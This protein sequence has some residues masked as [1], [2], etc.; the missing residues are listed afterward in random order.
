MPSRFP[1]AVLAL[2]C[3][4]LAL[5]ASADQDA[6]LAELPLETLLDLPV[7][8]ASR[9]GSRR[10]DSPA[11]VS[12][13]DRQQIEV[14][15]LR[16]LSDVL[17][18]VR[19]ID[20]SSDGSYTYA[21]VRGMSS[22]GDYNTRV[23][24]LIDGNRVNDNVF[25][26]A[27]LGTEFVLDLSQVERVE[28]I[29]GP[30]SAVYGANA[31]FGV[32]N[33]V[34]R[35]PGDGGARG[36]LRLSHRGAVDSWL[37]LDT[38]LGDGHLA[39]GAAWQ[40]DRGE[41]VQEAWFGAARAEGTARLVRSSWSA[42]WATAGWRVNLMTAR[43]SQGTPAAPGIVF[44]D[45]R[46][47]YIDGTTLLD[48]E[49]RQSLG[50][51]LDSVVRAFAGRYR[52]LG[53]YPIDY[54]PVTLNRDHADGDWWGLEGRL[55][56]SPVAQHRVVVGAELQR[57]QRQWQYNA[58]IDP[59]PW[60]YLNDLQRGWRWGAY[61]DDQWSLAEDWT[62]HAG[63]RLDHELGRFHTSPRLALVWR[64]T[65][66]WTWR[67]QHGRAFREPNAY[68]RRYHGDGPGSW[69]LNPALHGEQVRADEIG[70]NWSRGPWRVA[71]AAYR[72]Q[73]DGLTVLH[74]D[75]VADR[76]Q[77]RNLGARG[78]QGVEADVEAL[79]GADRYHLQL[80]L[81][82]TMHASPS[83]GAQTYPQRMAGAQAQ[84]QLG[85][86]SVLAVD[87]LARSRRGA[88]AGHLLL[89]AQWTLRSEGR[90][91]R[92]ALGLRNLANRRWYDPGPDPLRQPLVRGEA[93]QLWL[94]WTWE[95]PR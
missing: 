18:L 40:H 79:W 29:A 88:A 58:D 2:L 7:S 89:N 35:T 92:L 31:L 85:E 32:I 63:A 95:P 33:I 47:R 43:R 72:N 37:S 67:W 14:L 26:Q 64:A 34:T 4:A 53:D 73:A 28:F 1:R 81:N 84:W 61:L 38:A 24:L 20:I 94:S 3:L 9:L 90:S 74:H 51:H 17:R 56:W 39:L 80:G 19:G 86:R 6:E 27:M 62:L 10:S 44:G 30:G 60:L 78:T 52:Y 54:P 50:E 46:A 76:Y 77:V 82:R 48:V 13:I 59:S 91:W 83:L 25:D 12:V 41:A 11:S 5:P 36:G 42:S 23:L 8:G 68:E 57:Q 65:P 15:G 93:R 55:L 70:V 21:A 45:T 22:I 66:E 16:R 75:P 71:A 69:Q 87:A 49:H